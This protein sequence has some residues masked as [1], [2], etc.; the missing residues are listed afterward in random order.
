MTIPEDVDS[1]SLGYAQ[2][3]V[4]LNGLEDRIRLVAR[5]PSDSLIPLDDLGLNSIDFV[6]TNPPFYVSEEEM[7]SSAKAKA[8]PPYSACTGAP[9]EMVCEGGELAFVGRILTESIALRDRVRWYT[10]MFGKA[11]S[12]ESFVER[13]RQNEI[14]NYAITE[15]SPGNKTRRWAVGW[16]FGAMR[17]A[18]NAARGT[19]AAMG[20][21]LLPAGVE[22]DLHTSPATSG[23][24]PLANRITH[25][26]G[27]LELMSWE[28][29]P[30]KL[31]GLGRAR[32]NVWSRAWRRKKLREKNDPS[33]EK[34]GSQQ[35]ETCAFGFLVTID[36]GRTENTTRVR[37][38]EGHDESLFE[39]FSGFL[40]RRVS[41]EEG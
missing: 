18:R 15:F 13:L 27:S 36:V 23:V 22:V 14:D 9:V 8:R 2:K 16:S 25:E 6:M 20:K 3:N 37:W 24:G 28:W 12:V 40:K 33:V 35:A 39:S 19:K 41:A 31:R 17:P 30:D 26:I 38:V 21:K 32:E 10:S 1:E 7:M 4:K 5:R 29:E 11:S 34:A